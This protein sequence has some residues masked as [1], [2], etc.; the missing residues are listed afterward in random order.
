[1]LLQNGKPLVS[2]LFAELRDGEVLLSL[3]EILTAQQY[4][5]VAAHHNTD[6]TIRY[7]LLLRRAS[8]CE[9]TLT[10]SPTSAI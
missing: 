5:S 6:D 3:L 2:D 10:L 1:M 8:R 9:S 4:V 7:T